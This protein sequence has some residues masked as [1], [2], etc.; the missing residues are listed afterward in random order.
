LG[1]Q[2]EK[3][4][5]WCC[6]VTGAELGIQLTRKNCFP[7]KEGNAAASSGPDFHRETSDENMSTY[8]NHKCNRCFVSK[9]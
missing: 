7:A 3:K 4:H 9:E 5:S 1:S 6:A 8:S 2:Q